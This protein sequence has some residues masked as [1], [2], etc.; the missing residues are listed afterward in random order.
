MDAIGRLAGGVAHDFN[1]L[2]SVILNRTDFALR[3]RSI[4]AE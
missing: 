2:L 4:T 1:N 3:D